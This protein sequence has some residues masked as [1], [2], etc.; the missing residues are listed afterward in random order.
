MKRKIMRILVLYLKTGG[1]HVG[2]ARAIKAEILHRYSEYD[3]ELH[4][5]DGIAENQKWLKFI[6]ETGYSIV[7][8]SLPFLWPLLYETSKTPFFMRAQAEMLSLFTYKRL[9]DIIITHKIDKI[10]N[11]HFLLNIPIHRALQSIDAPK[12]PVCTVVLDPFT[13]HPYW[14][15]KQTG[16]LITFSSRA[17]NDCINRL[18]KQKITQTV[19]E[20]P[21]LINHRFD[22][23][24]ATE[25]LKSLKLRFGFRSDV[26]LVLMAGGGEGLPHAE[27]YVAELCK[28]KLPIQIAVVCGKNHAQELAVKQM[29]R[30]YG[31]CLLDQDQD[32]SPSGLLLNRTVVRVYGFV[33]FMYELMNMADAVACKAGPATLFEI[34]SLG[35]KPIITQY[36]YGQERGN[37]DFILRNN[38]GWYTPGPS[39]MVKMVKQLLTSPVA[40]NSRNEHR[41]IIKNGAEDLARFIVER[42]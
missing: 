19:L 35:K 42:L 13:A 9:R 18:K 36:L 31:A 2:A 10:I 8:T 33:P 16:T 5:V 29:V 22:R 28:E 14:C 30:L 6:I 24:I 17:K 21:P 3:I 7:S 41:A 1:G 40:L 27:F 11:L 25:E 39:D 38:F 4:L 34:L 37:L 26:P 15:L 32:S 23:T 20:L 12:I